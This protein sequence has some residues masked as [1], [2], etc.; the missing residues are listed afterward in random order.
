MCKVNDEGMRISAQLDHPPT[1]NRF[2]ATL[3]HILIVWFLSSNF[4][5]Y[6]C[7]PT[8]ELS[9]LSRIVEAETD[10]QNIRV[11][12]SYYALVDPRVATEGCQ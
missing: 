8:K 6:T 7:T 2:R 5:Y 3:T 9:N 4:L 12:E 1:T 11:T 10:K